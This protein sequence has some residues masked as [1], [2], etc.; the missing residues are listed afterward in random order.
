MQMVGMGRVRARTERG[1]EGP[2]GGLPDRRQKIRLITRTD[3]H[4]EP[5]R[6]LA[7]LET[8]NIERSPLRVLAHGAAG[9]AVASAAFMPAADAQRHQI[10]AEMA[11]RE[12]MDG[13]FNPL[14]D[15]AR[16][17]ATEDRGRLEQDATT[18]AV[19]SDRQRHHLDGIDHDA[20]LIGGG[21]AGADTDIGA[22][23]KLQGRNAGRRRTSRNRCRRRLVGRLR[24]QHQFGGPRWR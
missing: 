14:R 7:D 4:R 17:L 2:A 22:M 16:H 15:H 18:I 21:R 1:R 12:R 10:S 11:F 23:P 24:L 8:E 20:G 5:V 6:R 9:T 19:A 3:G 13:R